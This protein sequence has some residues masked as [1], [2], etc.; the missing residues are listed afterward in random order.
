MDE[1]HD[2]VEKLTHRGV[3]PEEPDRDGILDKNGNSH[4]YEPCKAA[5]A[6][7]LCQQFYQIAREHVIPI[8]TNC[9][10]TEKNRGKLPIIS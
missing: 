4:P 10:R 6:R 1:I 3:Q 8:Y 7:Q 5:K 2:F 9:S